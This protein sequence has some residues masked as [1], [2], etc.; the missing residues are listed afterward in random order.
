V[1]IDSGLAG[2]GAGT[3]GANGAILLQK[4]GTGHSPIY[5]GFDPAVTSFPLNSAPYV[6]YCAMLL[7]CTEIAGNGTDGTALAF[8]N[9]A[10]GTGS[11]PFHSWSMGA[12]L[13]PYGDINHTAVFGIS[14]LTDT[15][16]ANQNPFQI[17]NM[18]EGQ[19]QVLTSLFG[20][21]GFTGAD[22]GAGFWTGIGAGNASVAKSVDALS[23]GTDPSVFRATYFAGFQ[24]LTNTGFTFG[25]ATYTGAPTSASNGSV[26]SDWQMRVVFN[27][28]SITGATANSAFLS[29]TFGK[30][31]WQPPACVFSPNNAFTAAAMSNFYI[32][33][34]STGWT[35]YAGTVPAVGIY[36]FSVLCAGSIP[37]TTGIDP[38][39]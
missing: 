5:M 12:E 27:Q 1:E 3:T 36:K 4:N 20:I 25:P 29:Y 14:D 22:I 34:T 23:A 15:N 7:Y 13:F 9:Y 30:T 26:G 21:L 39:P 24:T 8:E 31:E 33:K 11:V 38:I 17:Y 19:P 18:V 35:I 16:A 28:A 37:T 6:Q 10:L 32:D 2:A